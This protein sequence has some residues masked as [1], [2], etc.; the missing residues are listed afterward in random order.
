VSWV[1]ISVPGAKGNR[2]QL[3]YP[4]LPYGLPTLENVHVLRLA[5]ITA[6][7][8]ALA[9]CGMIDA[10]GSSTHGPSKVT[11]KPRRV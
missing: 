7:A 2:A 8:I 10:M 11:W 9:A 6:L 4:I 1:D 3:A 5:T